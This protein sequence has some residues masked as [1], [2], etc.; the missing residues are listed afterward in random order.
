M[1]L[2]FSCWT[3]ASTVL[4]GEAGSKHLVKVSTLVG[5]VAAQLI[6][7]NLCISFSFLSSMLGWVA[8]LLVLTLSTQLASVSN[9][10]DLNILFHSIHYTT[11]ESGAELFNCSNAKAY[12]DGVLVQWN[13]YVIVLYFTEQY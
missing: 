8:H 10:T 5:C 12:I 6:P 7:Q 11:I 9:A 1:P 4:P 13:L 2:A 3:G